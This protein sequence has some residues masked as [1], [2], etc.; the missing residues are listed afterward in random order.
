MGASVLLDST[1]TPCNSLLLPAWPMPDPLDNIPCVC[2]QSILDG[3]IES[4]MHHVDMRPTREQVGRE[5]A[6]WR[7]SR[8]DALV[9]ITRH[10]GDRWVD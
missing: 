8:L 3:I 4:A 6:E 7:H 10:L 9:T 2:I 5:V 1:D